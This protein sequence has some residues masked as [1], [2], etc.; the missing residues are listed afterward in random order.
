VRTPLILLLALFLLTL[1]MTSRAQCPEDLNDNGAC[2]T[3]YVEPYKYTDLVGFPAYVEVAIRVTHDVPDPATDSLG[4]VIIPL[5]FT[6]S[7]AAAN[8]TIDWG[9][10]KCGG[11]DL[12]PS[13]H[14][15]PWNLNLSVF[16]HLPS[17]ED[18]Q[19]R[20]WMMD[21][22]A[23]SEG[24]EWDIR[25][26]DLSTQSDI[27]WLGLVVASTVDQLFGE[28]SRVLIATMTFTIDDTT[29]ICIDSCFWPPN[30]RLQFADSYATP[31]I[32]RHNLPVC[33]HTTCA[34]LPPDPFA[35]L[36]PTKKAF[37]PRKVGFDW[38]TTADPNAS[39][40]VR[41]DL[42]VSASYHFSP[43]SIT[44]DSNLTASEHLKT[45]DYGTHYWK[46][47]AK[48]NRGAERW[49][50]ETRLFVVTGLPQQSIGDFNSDGSVDV[51]DVVF[52]INYLYR[53]GSA[54]NSIEAGD[55]NCDGTVDVGDVV[56]LVNYLFRG[57]PPPCEP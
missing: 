13:Q 5:C 56:Y 37:T 25:I 54:P 36:S 12:Y 40:Q 26:L 43:D 29:T 34:N 20:N 1:G 33:F 15:V 8:A 18:P 57:G 42:W 53:S 9:K 30:G 50:D 47:K 48:D 32:P 19:I 11:E 55:V 3:L 39:D 45:L 38:E 27:F 35:L 24:L 41:Y 16:R 23:P 49:S 46:V 2:D 28:G 6:S 52:A 17:M 51:G 31:F 14:P 4:A 21:L 44:V 7:N 22:S 10:N